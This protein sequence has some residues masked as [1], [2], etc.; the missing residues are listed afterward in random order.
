[1]LNVNKEALRIDRECFG[2]NIGAVDYR[3]MAFRRILVHSERFRMARSELN[4][5][6]K[7]AA[8]SMSAF[9]DAARMLKVSM[10]T[11]IDG[12]IHFPGEEV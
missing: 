6:A 11:N 3:K 7:G 5:A 12:N 4:E 10:P 2:R 9:N 8:A 1:M